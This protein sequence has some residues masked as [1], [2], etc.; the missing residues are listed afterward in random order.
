MRAGDK[1][2]LS[3]QV[4][5]H[6]PAFKHLRHAALDHVVGQET[7]EALA[8]ELDAAFCDLAAFGTQQPGDRLQSRGLAGAVGAEEGGNMPLL[9][10]QRDALQHQN[11]AVIDDFDVVECQHRLGYSA[12]LTASAT[13]SR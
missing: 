4:L 6:A 8:V 10:V 5:E 3:R 11:H 7:V 1:V 12:F 9:G 13:T 2:F